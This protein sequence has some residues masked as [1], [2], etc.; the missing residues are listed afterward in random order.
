M[1]ADTVTTTKLQY[2]GRLTNG[3]TITHSRLGPCTFR[4]VR[5][6]GQLAVQDTNNRWLSLDVDFPPTVKLVSLHSL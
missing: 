3:D 2:E 4:Y 1:T 6:D 5:S